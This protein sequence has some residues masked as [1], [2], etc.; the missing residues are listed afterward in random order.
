MCGDILLFLRT[1]SY[2]VTHTSLFYF[3]RPLW[4]IFATQWHHCIDTGQHRNN[5]EVYT[6]STNFGIYYSFFFL[7]EAYLFYV[8]IVVSRGLFYT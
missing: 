8:L 4:Q 1:F 3:Q 6:F 5:Y 7:S 2:G